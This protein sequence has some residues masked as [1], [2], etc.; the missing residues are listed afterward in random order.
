MILVGS[1]AC[2][3]ASAAR[4]QT[5]CPP[6]PKDAAAAKHLA[7]KF[8]RYA[9]KFFD[10]KLYK[11]AMNAWICSNKMHSHPLSLFN[12]AKAAEKARRYSIAL[13]YYQA[14]LKVRPNAP[15]KK[16]IEDKIRLMKDMVQPGV[17]PSHPPPRLRGSPP[18]SPPPGR[19]ITPE[20]EPRPPKRKIGTLSI[21]G[22]ATVGLGSALAV[23]GVALGGKALSTKSTFDDAPEG[24]PWAPEQAGLYK[25]YDKFSTGAWV[26]IGLGLATIATGAVLLVLGRKHRKKERISIM[27]VP[28]QGGGMVTIGSRF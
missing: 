23:V 27:P 26:C 4:A 16:T 12:V 21:A 20:P 6:K 9:V 15:E 17:T 8:W 1:I 18:P 10:K 3:S 7:G 28:T 13:K 11:H 5:P 24:T 25:D 19:R 2:I 22:W 14:Y